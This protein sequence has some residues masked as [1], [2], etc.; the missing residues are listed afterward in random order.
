MGGNFKY[1]SK[2]FVTR[3][4]IANGHAATLKGVIIV[5]SLFESR[6]VSDK[7]VRKNTRLEI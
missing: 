4:I 7:I 5:L 3:D 2:K 6:I 1:P